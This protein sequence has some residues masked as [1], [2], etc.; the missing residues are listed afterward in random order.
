MSRLAA[1]TA[2][3]KNN[4]KKESSLADS[5]PALE[6]GVSVEEVFKW[7][8]CPS[9]LCHNG[10]NQEPRAHRGERN[11]CRYIVTELRD[12][13]RKNSLPVSGRKA[14]L[15]ERVVGH[16]HSGSRG[17]SSSNDE[18]SEDEEKSESESEGEGTH[19]TGARCSVVRI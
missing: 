19:P 10:L 3:N 8:L 9:P 2:H 11:E 12:F 15:V 7:Y 6:K 1:R 14:D 4:N 17:S 16:L 18:S 13:L 5:K